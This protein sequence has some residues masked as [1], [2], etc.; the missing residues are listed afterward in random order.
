MG[1][2]TEFYLKIPL[3]DTY[4]DEKQKIIEKP[5]VINQD[6]ASENPIAVLTDVFE[7]EIEQEIMEKKKLLGDKPSILIVED[8][9]DVRTYLTGLLKNDY[10]FTRQTMAKLV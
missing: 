6:S 10:R 3:W 9:E 8:S 5:E 7:K 4:L 1:K 2:G